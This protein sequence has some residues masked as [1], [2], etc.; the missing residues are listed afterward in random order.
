MVD[1]DVWQGGRYFKKYIG[2]AKNVKRTINQQAVTFGQIYSPGG[3]QFM[4]ESD[5]AQGAPL[6]TFEVTYYMTLW[7]QTRN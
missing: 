2:V 7:G 3:T 5:A 6:G 4:V 1:Y